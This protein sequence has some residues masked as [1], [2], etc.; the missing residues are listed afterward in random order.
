MART[1][2]EMSSKYFMGRLAGL[3]SMLIS[4]DKAQREVLM[5]SLQQQTN[6]ALEE[7]QAVIVERKQTFDK[8]LNS[9]YEELSQLIEKLGGPNENNQLVIEEANKL[10]SEDKTW[11]DR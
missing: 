7:I 3:S 6:Q 2:F 5:Q 8:E 1:Y 11:G 10:I 4:R 9:R